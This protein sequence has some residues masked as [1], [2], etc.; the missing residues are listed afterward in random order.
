MKMIR[1][2]DVGVNL[3]TRPGARLAQRLDET[4]AIRVIH[5][6]LLTPVAAIHEM[7]D[8]AGILDSQLAGHYSVLAAAPDLKDPPLLFTNRPA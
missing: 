5:K 4:L 6:D 7:V 8:R 2:Q 1:H 3:T